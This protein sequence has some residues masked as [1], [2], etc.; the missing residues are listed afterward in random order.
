[1]RRLGKHLLGRGDIQR[2]VALARLF[3]QQRFGQSGG[4]GEGVPDQQ[5]APAAMHRHRLGGRFVA[6][7]GVACLQ[8]FVGRWLA[9]QQA[10]A[11]S[12]GMSFHRIRFL[13][14]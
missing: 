14:R 11:V 2:Y 4:I 10:L 13:V 3:V 8:A 1:M 9:A 7:F 5:P 12:R 6:V